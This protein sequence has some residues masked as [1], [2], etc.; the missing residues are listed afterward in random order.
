MAGSGR[1]GLPQ[2]PDGED[3]GTFLKS[4]GRQVKLF[5]ERAGLTQP[6]LAARLLYGPDL[7]GSVEQGKR[8][9]KP[10]LIDKADEVL[11]AGGILRAMKGEV[12]RARY[13]AFFRDAA[14]LEA[15]AIELCSYDSQVIYGLLQTEEYARAVLSMRRPMLD[16]ETIE[17]RVAARMA[18]QDIFARKPAPL[19]SFVIEEAVLQRP[20]GGRRV[21]REQ[22][23]QLLLVGQKRNV[24][25][26]V[27]PTD[28]EDHAGADGPLVLITPN[29]GEQVAY[30][31]TQGRSNLIT[32]RDEVRAMAAR[33]G[34]IRSQALPPRESLAFIEKSLG[35]L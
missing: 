11:D 13:P 4:F 12:A 28:R 18:R 30:L 27:M 16:E 5:R 23:E 25:I 33:Y 7:I 14:K 29:G 9:P 21:L 24:E 2:L 8:I 35:G 19:M 26:Q 6:E 20:L 3:S 34:I 17:E 15:L 1:T 32:H 22:L 31:E 10:E